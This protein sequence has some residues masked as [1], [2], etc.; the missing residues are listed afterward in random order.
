MPLAYSFLLGYLLDLCLG[1]PPH[2]PHPV[3]L[4]GRVCRFWEEFFYRPNIWAGVWFWLAVMGTVG[5]LIWGGAWMLAW[6]PPLIAA[7]VA[8]YFIYATLA[9]RALHLESRRVEEALA[10]G[11]LAGAR[12]Y[13]SLIVGRQTAHLSVEEVRRAVLETIAENLSDGVVAPIF[14]GLLLG[15]PGMLLYKA[16]NTMDS[17]VGYK[18]YR[19]RAFGRLPA[20]LDDLLGYLP[21]RLSALLITGVAP[22]VGL[23]GAGA[24]RTMWR[25]GK[26]S[27]SPNAGWP[28]AALAGALG[29]R[30]GGPSLYFGQTVEKP[31][32]G[33]PGRPPQEGDYRQAVLLLYGASALMAALTFLILTLS[34]AGPLGLWGLVW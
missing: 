16:V 3:R 13:L 20:R 22:W 30:L 24:W 7:G 21:A 27:S 28:E 29:V 12:Q 25:D 19:Y 6:L 5:A 32:I 8:T 14:Y 9:T 26:K 1:D 10:A 31:F 18:N 17:M 15:V 2:W 4:I 34:G 11:D 23:D 33:E